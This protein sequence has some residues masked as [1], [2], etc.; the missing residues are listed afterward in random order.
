MQRF[1]QF[2]HQPLRESRLR[3]GTIAACGARPRWVPET[4]EEFDEV[5]LALSLDGE[6]DLVVTISVENGNVERILLGQTPAGDD[7]ADF[8]AFTPEELSEVL[9]EKGDALQGLVKAI[10]SA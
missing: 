8:S 10:T 2:L 9:A 7:D 5:E 4:L 1:R 6:R 3:D